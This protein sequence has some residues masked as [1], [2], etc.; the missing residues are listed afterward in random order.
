MEFIYL[1]HISC[2]GFTSLGLNS[3][4]YSNGEC[5]RGSTLPSLGFTSLGPNSECHSNGGCFG[6]ENVEVNP[7]FTRKKY[8]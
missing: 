8:L 3:E 5:F 6:V 1:Y 2:L 4:F 7:F